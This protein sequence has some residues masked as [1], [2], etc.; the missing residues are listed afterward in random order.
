MS[1]VSGRVNCLLGPRS[2]DVTGLS[3]PVRRQVSCQPAGVTNRFNV[4]ELS[5]FMGQLPL[6]LYQ[7]NHLF[8]SLFSEVGHI[9]RRL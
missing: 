9:G 2:V 8:L 6:L 5:P 7:K 1:R 4:Q 3:G